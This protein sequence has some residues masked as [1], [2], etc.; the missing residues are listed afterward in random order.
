MSGRFLGGS[1]VNVNNDIDNSNGQSRDVL[2]QAADEGIVDPF[3]DGE[4]RRLTG[5]DFR[6]GV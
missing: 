4:I 1:N 3:G 6:G 2:G 5:M